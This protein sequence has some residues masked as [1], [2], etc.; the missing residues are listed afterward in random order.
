MD[1]HHPSFCH[2]QNSPLLPDVEGTADCFRISPHLGTSQEGRKVTFTACGVEPE[3]ENVGDPSLRGKGICYTRVTLKATFAVPPLE[4]NWLKV[5]MKEMAPTWKDAART[6]AVFEDTNS[7]SR[8]LISL[9]HLS[10]LLH[11]NSIRH[12]RQAFL[13]SFVVA[14]V[15]N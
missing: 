14:A 9:C 5:D 15:T 8:S 2:L 6:V 7:F 1:N 12:F 4:K 13:D 3:I 11:I 10:V